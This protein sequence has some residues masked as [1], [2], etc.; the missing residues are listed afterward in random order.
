MCDGALSFSQVCKV[1]DALRPPSVVILWSRHL[2][3]TSAWKSALVFNDNKVRTVEE[4]GFLRLRGLWMED[5][6]GR[7]DGEQVEMSRRGGGD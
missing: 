3:K 6:G 7:R 5:L 2:A 4:L 1:D